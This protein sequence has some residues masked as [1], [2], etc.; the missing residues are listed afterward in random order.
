MG[1]RPQ[2]H[3]H[4]GHPLKDPNLVYRDGGK[5]RE[6]RKCFNAR[7]RKKRK[8]KKV[9]IAKKDRIDRVG[10]EAAAAV[11]SVPAQANAAET[12]EEQA[13]CILCG[14][15]PQDENCPVMIDEDDR[16]VDL[17]IQCYLEAKQNM[18]RICAILPFDADGQMTLV[19]E[20][21]GETILPRSVAD[22]LESVAKSVGKSGPMGG[23]V[24]AIE[25][26]AVNMKREQAPEPEPP[27]PAPRRVGCPHGFPNEIVCPTCRSMR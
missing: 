13:L 4:K 6:C 18:H 16:S 10:A 7:F 25:S 27:K 9:K 14:K 15:R 2:T 1:R 21:G 22:E 17:C 19:G 5:A 8:D 26:G 23:E 20:R 24:I 11:D 3:C 12:G